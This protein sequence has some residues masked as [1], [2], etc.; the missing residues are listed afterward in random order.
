MSKKPTTVPGKN[1]K[2]ETKQPMIILV[3]NLKGGTG[4]STIAFNLAV[5]SAYQQRRTLLVDA[6]PQH[7]TSDFITLRR[8]EGHQPMI[9]SLVAEERRL[10]EELSN[11]E[12]IFENIV[13][14]IAAGDRESFRAALKVADR[15]VIPLLPGQADVWAL[16][17]VM[18]LVN[19]ARFE[20][21][22]L[23]VIAVINRADTNAQVR[24]TQETEEA[25]RQIGLPIAKVQIG[26]RVTFRRSLTEGLGVIE[27]EPRSRAAKEMEALAK[28]VLT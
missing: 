24:E 21:P 19:A 14:D 28:E 15:L 17:N 27:W 13:V 18:E 10:G 16:H 12:N 22:S 4:K 6:D 25:L 3:G 23:E 20:K 7:T 1:Q 2:K 5:W 11:V 26:N 9:Y 8:E